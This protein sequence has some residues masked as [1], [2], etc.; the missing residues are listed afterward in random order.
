MKEKTNK[1]K[2]LEMWEWLRDNAGKDKN[3]YFHYL[4][5]INL[6]NEFEDCWACY[7]AKDNCNHCPITFNKYRTYGMCPCESVGSAYHQWA[8]AVWGYEVNVDNR[9]IHPRS[10]SKYFSNKALAYHA[11]NKMVNLI[12]TTWKE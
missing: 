3:D 12:K 7:E 4:L 8:N 1:Q 2:C 9:T 10:E 6:S 5:S 11:A